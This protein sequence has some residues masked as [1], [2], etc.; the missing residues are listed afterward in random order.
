MGIGRDL[1]LTTCRQAT[2]IPSGNGKFLDTALR[3][4]LV[5]LRIEVSHP[6]SPHLPLLIRQGRLSKLVAG[7]VDTSKR[8]QQVV[9]DTTCEGEGQG[10]TALWAVFRVW[11]VWIDTTNAV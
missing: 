3:R 9:H 1:E 5:R 8:W 6:P 7:H 11:G 2:F 10:S 4:G